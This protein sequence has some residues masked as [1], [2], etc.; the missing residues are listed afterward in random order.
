MHV[1]IA[2]CRLS[3]EGPADELYPDPDSELLCI[4]LEQRGV[5]PST[6]SWDDPSLDWANFDAVIIRSTWDGVTRPSEY[7]Q[8][9]HKVEAATKLLPSAAI[10]EW[11]LD[12]VYLRDLAKLGVPTIPTTWV[13]PGGSFANPIGEFIVKPTISA[14]ARDTARYS[15]HQLEAARDHVNSLGADGRTAMVQDFVQS[16]EDEGELSIIFIEGEVSH[17]IG[18]GSFLELDRGV[19]D[20]PWEQITYLGLTDPTIDQADLARNVVA[21]IEKLLGEVLLF[22]RIDVVMS[23]NGDPFVL[24]VELFDPVLSLGSMP[25]AVERLA[26]AIVARVGPSE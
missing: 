4:A 26:D 14:G 12:K 19:I 16:V 22:A 25:V 6:V 3:P 15:L 2:H 21:V 23:D 24:E 11:S 8:W 7:R 1:A 17:A 10:V 20:N 9:V 13:R 5:T 18:K